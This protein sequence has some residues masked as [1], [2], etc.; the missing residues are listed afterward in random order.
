MYLPPKGAVK[1]PSLPVNVSLT[2]MPASAAPSNWTALPLPSLNSRFDYFG[3]DT[4]L[5]R[6]LMVGTADLDADGARE[7]VV[8]GFDK[9]VDSGVLAGGNG[10]SLEF[11]AFKNH[12]P[13]HFRVGAED[14][15]AGF[16][17][18]LYA[19]QG[20]RST[21]YTGAAWSAQFTTVLWAFNDVLLP[22]VV[23]SME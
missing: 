5:F 4:D 8:D 23:Q 19:L 10:S 11:A 13:M 21:W 3:H 1:N 7:L 18:D 12:G 17:Q 6:F 16:I 20:R 2:N 14:L 22:K 15:E 9:M